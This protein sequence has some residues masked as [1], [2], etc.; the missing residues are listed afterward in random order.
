[1]EVKSRHHLRSDEVDTITTALSE[2]LGVELDADSFEK[3]EFDDSDWDVVLVDGDP[4]VLYLNGE[5][6]LTVQGANQYPPEKHIVTVD[7]G[8]VSFVSDGADI[9]RPGITEA[10]DD[11]SEGDLVVINE[12]SH[13]KF[14]A[15]GRA[16]TDGDDMVGDSGKVVKSLH[17]VGDDLFEFSV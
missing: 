7:A 15:V 4:L 1:M 2:N 12:E 3:V 8:A 11:I 14:L 9:M 6:F 5:P 16:Q 13:G 10:D 17:H